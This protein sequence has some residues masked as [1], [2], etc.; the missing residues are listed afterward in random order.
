M[1]HTLVEVGV[2]DVRTWKSKTL[3]CA[4]I[5]CFLSL[6]VALQG[7]FPLHPQ[8][9]LSPPLLLA[10]RDPHQ[11]RRTTTNAEYRCAPDTP[12]LWWIYR[13]EGFLCD[14]PVLT[15][16]S[17]YACWMA[18]R[19]PL[20]SRLRSPSLQFGCTCRWTGWK[21]R[22]SPCSRLTHAVSTRTWTW[23]NPCGNW[24]WQLK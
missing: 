14:L 4:L 23:R 1:W 17:R 13:L 2:L 8:L 5:S 10:V 3:L 12:G 6:E 24:V 11:L 15:P 7:L 21:D 18:Q 9:K 16:S 22:T 19:W 20:F